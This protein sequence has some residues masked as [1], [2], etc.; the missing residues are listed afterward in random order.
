ME[1]NEDEGQDVGCD[2]DDLCSRQPGPVSARP[3]RQEVNADGATAPGGPDIIYYLLC[4]IQI[5]I[6]PQLVIPL[7]SGLSHSL[8]Y[9]LT[10][11]NANGSTQ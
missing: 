6:H 7:A 5:A 11:F 9:Q 1:P 10:Q 8:S 4:I 3:D 2:T